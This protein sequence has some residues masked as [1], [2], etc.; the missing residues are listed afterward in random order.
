MPDDKPTA[1]GQQVTPFGQWLD[2]VVPA[3]F[4]TDAELARA[5][6]VNQGNVTR[7]RRG[8]VPAVQSL[9]KLAE[10]TGV[11]MEYLIRVAGYQPLR[12]DTEAQR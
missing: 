8:R 2:T 7:W 10:V 12:P 5:L 4:K 3:I 6:G 9:Y 11:S 1:E